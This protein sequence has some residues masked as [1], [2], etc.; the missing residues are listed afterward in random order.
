MTH[1]IQIFLPRSGDAGKAFEPSSFERVK[2]ELAEQFGGVTAYLRASAEGLWKSDH[3]D[4]VADEVAVFEV[5]VEGIDPTWWR[6][7]REQLELRFNQD[8]ILIRA[9]EV[10]Q[11]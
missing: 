6:A 5:M 9:N 4:L 8:E 2:Y 3:G 10:Q 1:L 11:L 7:Y